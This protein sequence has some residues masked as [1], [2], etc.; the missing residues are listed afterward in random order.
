M[1]VIPTRVETRY[2]L[3]LLLIACLPR[4]GALLLLPQEARLTGDSGEYMD[5]ARGMLAGRGY[6]RDLVAPYEPY[7]GRVP[8]YPAFIAAVWFLTGESAFA[9]SFVQSALDALVCLLVYEVARPRFGSRT[10]FIAGLLYALLPFTIGTSGQIM[11]EALCSLFVAGAL[12]AHTLALDSIKGRWAWAG[13]S[14]VCWGVVVLSRPYLAPLVPIAGWLLAWELKC[15]HGVSW[16]AAAVICS[17]VGAS[18]A[19]AVGPWVARNAHVTRTTGAPFVALQLYGSRPPFTTM[20]TPGFSRFMASFD[21]PFLWVDTFKAPRANYLT[22]DEKVETHALFAALERNAGVVTP[23]MNARFAHLAA[24]RYEAAPLRLYLWRPISMAL[25]TWF[26]P[27]S[28]S[29]RTGRGMDTQSAPR[30]MVLSFLVINVTFSLASLLGLGTLALG[31]RGRLFDLF[32]LGF[33]PVITTATVVYVA[34]RESRLTVPLFPV[35]AIA[36]A[37][38]IETINRWHRT[39][40]E[41]RARGASASGSSASST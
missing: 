25:K 38:G 7:L 21:E 16:R 35:M 14:G 8:G 28:G 36:A 30:A 10:A 24:Q 13:V 15:R 17:I 4:F 20:Y 33:A 41:W 5:L 27:R 19:L 40:T 18:A 29:F 6:S 26:S 11:S 2:L 34:M 31:G 39:W 3:L 22:R 1:N 12:Y 37:V 32:I 23:E 9:V